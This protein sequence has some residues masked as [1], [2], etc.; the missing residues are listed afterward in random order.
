MTS[1]VVSILELVGS[2]YLSW[3]IKIIDVLRSN[4]LWRLVK[5][6][7]MKPNDAKIRQYGKIDVMTQ[8]D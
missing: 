7:K 5:D 1:E 4:N 6:D 3:K 2:N 8:N